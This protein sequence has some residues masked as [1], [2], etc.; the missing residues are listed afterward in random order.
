MIGIS[1][2]DRGERRVETV[3]SLRG[4]VRLVGGSS[5]DEVS[6]CAWKGVE[7]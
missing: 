2:G 7:L 5:G 3:R 6:V 4:E 1:E